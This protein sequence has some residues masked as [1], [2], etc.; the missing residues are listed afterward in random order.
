MA[1]GV[2]LSPLYLLAADLVLYLHAAFVVFVIAGQVGILA[3]HLAGWHW[4]RNGWFRLA[5]RG[6]IAVVV[7]Q[8]WLGVLCPLTTLETWLRGKSGDASYP[9][10]FIAYWVERILYYDLPEWVFTLIYTAFGLVVAAS[11]VWIRP[12]PVRRR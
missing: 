7:L 2:G 10:A 5:H 1:V 8:A 9:G 3:G 6:A 11:W 4:V 12:H